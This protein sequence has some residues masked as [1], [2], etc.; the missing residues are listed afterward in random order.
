MRLLDRVALSSRQQRVARSVV[1]LTPLVFLAL[2][3]WSGGRFHPLLT[4]AGVLLAVLA[5]LVPESNVALGLLVYLAVLWAIASSATLD[6]W[7]LLATADLLAFHLACTLASYGPPGLVLDAGLLAL[8]R[9]RAVR[10]LAAAG[11]VWLVARLLAFLDLPASG[12]AL[13]LALLVFL[14]W[15]GALSVGLGESRSEGDA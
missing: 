8:W 2:V 14:T 6:G 5:A 1:L 13:G 4:V 7:T 15:V 11:A 9:G 12:L 3:T 10:C